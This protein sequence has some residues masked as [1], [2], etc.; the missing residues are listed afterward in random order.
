MAGAFFDAVFIGRSSESCRIAYRI[1]HKKQAK[2]QA[3]R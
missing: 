3:A 2:I 1:R